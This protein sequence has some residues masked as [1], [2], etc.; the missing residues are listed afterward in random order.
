M[1]SPSP[2]LICAWPLL[3]IGVAVH[4]GPPEIAH[5]FPDFPDVHGCHVIT[6]EHFDAKGLSVWSWRAPSVEATVQTGLRQLGQAPPLPAT[7]PKGARRVRVLDVEKQTLVTDPIAGEVL[8]VKTPR[9]VSRPYLL[10]VAKPFWLSDVRV[11]PGEL[12]YIY[13]FGLRAR[14]RRTRV[15][16][17]NGKQ[18]IP[19]RTLTM[20][21]ARRVA[22]PRLVYFEVPRSITPGSYEVYIHNS[23]GGVYGWRHAGRAEVL[24]RET[25]RETVF[26]VK[27]PPFGAKGDGLTDDASAIQKAFT[28]ATQAGGGVVFL[29]PGTYR[30]SRTVLVPQRCE[31]RGA[32]RSNTTIL[33]TGYVPGQKRVRF[34][35]GG[36]SAAATVVRLLCHTTLSGVTVTGACA[37]GI[38]G[39]AT[40]NTRPATYDGKVYPTTERVTVKDCQLVLADKEFQ[41]PFRSALTIFNNAYCRV[42]NNEIVG[43]LRVS[44]S[45]RRLDVIGN[46]FRDG[47]IS[48]TG[49]DCLI[50]AN[51]FKDS[52][53]RFLFYPRRHCHIRFNEMHQ[54]FRHSWCNAEEIFLVHG[55]S[56][57]SGGQ[58]TGASP[59]TLVDQN[60]D[61]VPGEFD[62]ATVLIVSGRGFGQY[63]IVTGNTTDTL[64]LDRPWRVVPDKTS[65]YVV[66]MMF[67][68]NSFYANLN[69][70]PL[71]LSLWLDCIAN[72]VD[73]HRDVFAKGTDIWGQDRTGIPEPR[74]TR[75]KRR[76]GKRTSSVTD[77]FHPAYY[78]VLM[79]SWMDGSYAHLWSGV[80]PR[81]LYAGPPMFANYI[82]GNKIRQPHMHRTGF[83]WNETA[84]G[85]VLVGNATGSGGWR[86]KGTDMTQ[87]QDAR[88]GL[89]HSVVQNNFLTFTHVGVSVSDFARKTFVVGNVFQQV[90]RPILD[91]G[92]RTVIRANRTFRVDATGER[93]QPI[94]DATG[95]REIRTRRDRSP[96]SSKAR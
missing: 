16:L 36:I 78:N 63:A 31:L 77:R 64:E 25:R 51:L 2:L 19:V 43:G 79:N 85:G 82:V 75:P 6:G 53:T 14:Y 66:G 37:E 3:G 70:T 41:P 57:K 49:S 7:P 44:G 96:R 54:A 71:R 11:R 72:V 92:A 60:K 17:N 58:P 95:K 29:P 81:N 67:V 20:A 13:G 9:G 28:A 12:L 34:L 61:W 27:D 10:L 24:P 47:A 38:G 46:T 45:A 76:A 84:L 89:S 55:G 83:A 1:R 50:D 32:G 52:P 62:E 59:T 73:L 80:D 26:N 48:G 69:N 21:R 87:P 39:S 56:R 42:L 8:W 15:V 35:W 90:A 5:V 86:P 65:E 40:V 74:R 30:V 91:W 4:A 93:D 94:P 23:Y 33:G 88:V 22:D 18:T 68:E